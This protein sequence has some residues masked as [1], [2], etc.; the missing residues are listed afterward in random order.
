MNI[1]FLGLLVFLFAGMRAEAQKSKKTTQAVPMPGTVWSAEKAN[2]WYKEHKWITGA[3]YIP[4]TA[5]NQLE[6]WQAETFDPAT[7][8][9]ACF[10]ASYCMENRQGWIQ[11]KNE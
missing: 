11:K 1:K 2:A 7:I 3:N 9:N 4:A 6:M 10:P 5:I 8:D